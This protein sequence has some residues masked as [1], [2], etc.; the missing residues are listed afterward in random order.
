MDKIIK[1]PKWPAKRIAGFATSL[2]VVFAASYTLLFADRTSRLNI[3]AERLQTAVVAEGLFQEF[4]P[5]SGTVIPLKTIYLDAIEGGRVEERFLEAGAFVEKGDVLLRISNMNLLLDVMYRE[6]ELFQQTN[7]LRNTRLAIEQRRL[8]LMS[9][10]IELDY[11][12]LGADRNHQRNIQLN[13]KQLISINDFEESLDLFNYLHKR[14]AII[15]ETHVQDSIY[16]QNQIQQ[17]EASLE[18]M[19]DNLGL[20]KQNLDNLTITAPVSGHLTSLN[21]E[22]GES[23]VRGERLG[24]IDVMDG[25]KVRI[26]IDE[27]YITRVMVGQS[28]TFSLGGT[29][30]KVTVYKIYPE[31]LN[32]QFEIDMAFGDLIPANVRRGQTLRIRLE[33]GELSEALLVSRGGFFQKT[34]GRW[35]YVVDPSGQFAEKREIRIG[36]QNQDSFEILSGLKP[37][38]KVII[39]S[40]SQFGDVDQLILK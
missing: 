36:R 33:L 7:N 23:K 22:I 13:E 29:T 8:E 32:G 27:H 1:K 24:Q 3:S 14:R 21:A 16:R 6:A 30:Y 38:E 9:Q 39:S 25:F 17:L 26:G 4:I 18:R 11:Q 19:S 20:V 31:V 10:L 12:I 40:Y 37:G 5:V 2:I 15:M 34:G 28:G 35:I